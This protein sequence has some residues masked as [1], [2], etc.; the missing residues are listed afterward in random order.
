MRFRGSPS[1]AEGGRQPG[2]RACPGVAPSSSPPPLHCHLT[3]SFSPRCHHGK[4][5][6]RFALSYPARSFLPGVWPSLPGVWGADPA[7][8]VSVHY[9]GS[10]LWCCGPWT[11]AKGHGVQGSRTEEGGVFCNP[12]PISAPHMTGCP[13]RLG[14]RVLLARSRRGPRPDHRPWAT[15]AGLKVVDRGPL[16][17]RCPSL[18][19]TA[20][21]GRCGQLVACG[22][23]EVRFQPLGGSR[24]NSTCALRPE[25]LG[26]P[27]R[28]SRG[29]AQESSH[30]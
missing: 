14:D 6:K 10:T 24:G 17:S 22:T 19:A 21:L 16:H 23:R 7:R 1:P 12:I 29:L 20:D 18:S 13:P 26:R 5:E 28:V 25:P 30:G 27:P 2:S 11:T 8:P 3:P 4:V 9:P 15:P